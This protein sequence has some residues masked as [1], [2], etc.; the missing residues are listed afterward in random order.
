M[1]TD[2]YSMSRIPWD[3]A[4]SGLDTRM[5]SIKVDDDTVTLVGLVI[6][7]MALVSHWKKSHK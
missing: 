4:S 1:V 5:T 6:C 2:G 7:T 3:F